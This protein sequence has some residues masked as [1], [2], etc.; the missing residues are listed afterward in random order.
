VDAEHLIAG[1]GLS[2]LSLAVRLAARPRSERGR[3]LVVDARTEHGA[4]RTW[5]CWRIDHPFGEAVTHR[6]PKWRVV[7][8]DGAIVER[9]IAS[10]PYEH[11]ASERLYSIALDALRR[12]DGVD[13]LLGRAIGEVAADESSVRCGDLR[14][15]VLWDARGGAPAVRA[16]DGDVAWS[17]HFVGW[18]VRTERPI[19]DPEVA[20]LMDFERVGQARGPH[21]VYVLPYAADEALV[22]D[23]YFSAEPLPRGEYED[24]IR[25][26]LERRRSGGLTI[27]RREEGSIPMTTAALARPPS[28]RI[29]PLGLRGG[30]AKPST[31]YAFAFVQRHSDA[32]A[33]LARDGRVPPPYVPVRSRVA[34][35]FDR[36]FLSYLARHPAD[37]PGIFT[38]LFERTDPAKLARFL[39]EEGGVRDHA[40]VMNGVPRLGVALDAVRSSRTWLRA[41]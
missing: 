29:V 15:R 38:E 23:T 24:G 26:W 11:V 18:V 14:A 34:T 20:T 8:A 10:R 1:A 31:G 33:R 13:V 2:G 41:R 17:Q 7:S 27:V 35:F 22:E 32:L 36:V 16:A 5:C 12:A 9:G 6:W 4:D 30:A 39:M 28:R 3:V 37:A 25:G 19:F 40:A 21:F